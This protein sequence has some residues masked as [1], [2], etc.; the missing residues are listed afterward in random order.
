MTTSDTQADGLVEEWDASRVLGTGAGP[1]LTAFNR[2]GVLGPADVHAALRLGRLGGE[3]DEEVLL[4]AALAVR[5]PRLGHVHADLLTIR[6]TVA[7][8]GDEDMDLDS[9]PWPEDVGAWVDRLTDSP[10]VTVG[11]AAATE[12]PFRLVGTAIYL[13]RY[14]RDEEAVAAA[15]ESRSRAAGPEVDDNALAAAVDR[16]FPDDPGGEQATAV[17]TAVGRWVSVV[18]GGPGTGKTTTV[19]RI[20]A[21]LADQAEAR[22]ARPPLMALAAPTGK[23]AARL[24]EA[25]RSEADRM[26]VDPSVRDR[27]RAVKASTLHRLLVRHPGNSSRFRHNRGNRLPHDVVIVD[28]TSMV[29]LW[30][31]ARLL[32]AVRP[33]ARLVLVGDPGQLSS[34]EAGAVL[35]DVVGPYAPRD[36]APAEP[37]SGR[38]L[39]GAISLLRA[40]HRFGGALAELANA[41]QKGDAERVVAVLRS[42]TSEADGSVRWLETDVATATP[43]DLE[44]VRKAVVDAFRPVVE[45]ARTGEA[46]A[47]L[48][49]LGRFRLLC[50]HRRG[51][52]GVATWNAE[53]AAWLA[54]AVD[55]FSPDAT[56]YPGR[57]VMIT[58]ND[59]SLRLFNGDTGVAVAAHGAGLAVAFERGTEPVL[60]SPA[61]LADVTTVHAMTVHKAQG[62]EFDTVAVLLPDPGSRVLTREL[63]YTAVTRARRRVWLVGTDTDVEAAVHRPV[64]RASGLAER[65]WGP[66]P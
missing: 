42:A 46:A 27:I 22:G 29:S 13:D 11:R 57:P 31:M 28:E 19:A 21:V 30:L 49:A 58:A 54:D 26:G 25:V 23:A 33:D 56:W 40:S 2:A 61:R 32:E 43:A 17:T 45:A 24:E 59:Y 18:A 36:S 65:L 34:V 20:M 62:S 63:L 41:I 14:W 1:L 66:Q 7:T 47:A 37:R 5:A 6:S 60:V 39:V 64:A 8:D 12:R 48:E 9:L 3:D 4:A 35:A 55:G 15:L 50:A 16:L 10:L 53:V 51:P 44:P 38:P 52:T